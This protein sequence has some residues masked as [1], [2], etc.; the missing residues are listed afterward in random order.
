MHQKK[1]HFIYSWQLQWTALSWA[2]EKCVLSLLLMVTHNGNS[3]CPLLRLLAILKCPM[4]IISHKYLLIQFYGL[5]FQV[6]KNKMVN[7]R[8]KNSPTDVI[9]LKKKCLS[10]ILLIHRWIV[11]SYCAYCVYTRSSQCLPH[12]YTNVCEQ[13]YKQ[14]NEQTPS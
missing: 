9:N 1:R 6:D 5:V 7:H 3:G 14:A 11:V 13:T 12:S 10:G 4:W 2:H 8:G